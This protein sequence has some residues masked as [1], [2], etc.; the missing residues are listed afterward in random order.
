M[1]SSL[2]MALVF[3]KVTIMELHKEAIEQQGGNNAHRKSRYSLGPIV[4]WVKPE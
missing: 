2:V 4:R 1:L 3:I